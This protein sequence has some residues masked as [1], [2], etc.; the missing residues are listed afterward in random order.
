MKK[1]DVIFGYHSV[2]E[3]I[4]SGKQ[5]DKIL[6]QKDL[7]GQATTAVVKAAN[8]NGIPFQF[9]PLEKIN[10]ITGKNHQGVLCFM[11]VV[12]YQDIEKVLPMIYDKGELP[13][14]FIL[15]R[16]TDVRNF[17]AI[18]RTAECAGVHAIV[19]PHKNTAQI[20][21]DAVK[22]SS[23]AIHNVDIC[24]VKNTNSIISF[25]KNSGLQ[26]VACTEKTDDTIYSVNFKL[27][28]AIIIGSEEDGISMELLAKAD[29]SA[30]IPLQGE[31]ASL[32]ASVAA[33]II[34]YEAVRQR[35][36]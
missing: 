22:T 23:G 27:P 35:L 30:K 26:V 18:I 4:K 5:I 9:V 11:S 33:G 21:A 36:Y 3:A 29:Y 20:N 8:D 1:S 34:A 13:L 28:T 6:L 2:M 15:D 12:T 17:G 25:L 10:R 24:R 16:I 31:V 7:R 14:L 19:I 32:N